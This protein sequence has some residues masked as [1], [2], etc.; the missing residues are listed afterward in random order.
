MKI[1]FYTDQTYLH[2]GLERVMAN[3]INYLCANTEIKIHVVTFEQKDNSPCYPMKGNISY[4]DLN[5]NYYRKISFLHPKN[6]IKVSKHFF[7]LKKKIREINPDVI[8]VCNYEYGFYFV[9]LLAKKAIKIKEY[10]SSKHFNF[11]RREQN[12]SFIKAL[13]YRF[14]DY[15]E[16]KYD[17]LVL[18]TRDE[19]N[20]YRSNNKIVIPN[21]IS[22][23]PKTTATLDQK[24]AISAGRIAPVKG[25]DKLIS[26]WKIVAEEYP[27][28]HLN[29]YGDGESNYVNTLKEQIVN[30]N[31]K[32]YVTIHGST[33]NLEEKLL[34][35]SMYIMSS[36]T[37]CFPMVLLEAMSC[38]LPV[39]SFDCP[40]GPRNIIRN[41]QDGILVENN[42]IKV[43][44]ENINHLIANP[45]IR[46]EL[47]KKA[48]LNVQKYQEDNIM[49][50]WL[51]IFNNKS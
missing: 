13:I 44:A 6:L 51:K 23:L 17:Y 39:I 22:N 24:N 14:S 7:K 15:F 37:E 35:S 31:L 29:I 34:Q 4:H 32:D 20:Y 21:A 42:N 33:D 1:I 50:T 2:G 11:L 28:W 19:L 43:L 27:D 12:N 45:T 16:S 30:L 5:I 48:R 38:G 25:F 8:I 3:K 18:L 36:E 41:N 40:N 9:P 47:G 49:K 26:A 46:K 10:H